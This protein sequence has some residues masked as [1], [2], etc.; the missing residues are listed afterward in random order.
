[1]KS[2]IRD[3]LFFV[4][5]LLAGCALPRQGGDAGGTV[6]SWGQRLPTVYVYQDLIPAENSDAKIEIASVEPVG[7]DL[8]LVFSVL[9]KK[10][11]LPQR[12]TV[13]DVTG[14]AP[15]LF[16]DDRNPKFM[17]GALVGN[18]H[19]WTWQMGPLAASNWSPAWLHESEHSLRVYR[20]TIVTGDGRRTVL[21]QGTDYPVDVKQYIIDALPAAAPGQTE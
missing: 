13:E 2:A 4:A 17:S 21:R 11:R 16:V 8:F 12:V 1:M 5:S 18:A 7:K 14:V 15:E 19:V 6:F 20:V 9:F 10:D 3:S